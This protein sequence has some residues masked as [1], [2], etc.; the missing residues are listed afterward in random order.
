MKEDIVLPK[1]IIFSGIPVKLSGDYNGD[2]TKSDMQKFIDD[3]FSK[4]IV[5]NENYTQIKQK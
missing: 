5:Y 4:E 1:N 3:Y 2:F